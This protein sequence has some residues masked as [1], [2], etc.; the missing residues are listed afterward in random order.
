MSTCM[1]TCRL[2]AKDLLYNG[3]E[4]RVLRHLLL[5][6]EPEP[7]ALAAAADFA[8]LTVEKIAPQAAPEGSLWRKTRLT[9][10]IDPRGAW[11]V[12]YGD[13][14]TAVAG[15]VAGGSAGGSAAAVLEEI[16][17]ISTTG[18]NHSHGP[19]A[20]AGAGVDGEAASTF[21][22][23]YWYEVQRMFWH[24]KLGNLVLLPSLAAAGVA[25]AGAHSLTNADYDIKV[26]VCAR[27][28]TST[29]RSP[30][31]ALTARSWC[32][33]PAATAAGTGPLVGWLVG[34]LNISNAYKCIYFYLPAC[35][36]C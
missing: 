12:L 3:G 30:G 7:V 19:T 26:C 18:T 11:P 33:A 25:G 13:A 15:A 35:C 29:L 6:C 22:V 2:E 27:L 20:G 16:T 31:S 17:T 36:L 14:G 8:N 4:T 21:T 9:S 5:R 10:A 23:A 28:W 32:A 1:H 24:G 34:L